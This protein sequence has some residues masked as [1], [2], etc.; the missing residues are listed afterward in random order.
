MEHH[1][2][3]AQQLN[4]K[5]GRSSINYF[6]V[7]AAFLVFSLVADEQVLI[8]TLTEYHPITLKDPQTA[9]RG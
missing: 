7:E 1:K 9:G 2:L 8:T 6:G 5:W 3:V 4:W